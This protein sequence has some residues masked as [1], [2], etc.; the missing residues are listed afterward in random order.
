M[1]TVCSP[2]VATPPPPGPTAIVT[3]PPVAG[4]VEPTP[5]ADAAAPLFAPTPTGDD[6]L[7]DAPPTEPPTEVAPSAPA[8]PVLTVYVDQS[9]PGVA[10]LQTIAQEWGAANGCVVTILPKSADDLRLDFVMAALAGDA[11][12]LVVASDTA[13]APFVA[14]DLLLPAGDWVNAADFA[15]PVVAAAAI[16]GTQWGIPLSVE[17][18][19]MLLYNKKLIAVPPATTNDL[20]RTPKPEAAEAIFIT[21]QNDPRWLLPW[22]NGWGG[23]V[24]GDDGRPT[25]NAPPMVSTF[26]FL[27][28]LRA[29]DVSPGMDFAAGSDLFKQ[30]RAA[31][32]VDG[33]WSVPW[34]MDAAMAAPDLLDLGVARLPVVAGTNGAAASY[35]GGRYV[36]VPRGTADARRELARA[37]VATLT[38]APTQARWASETRRLPAR[39]ETLGGETVQNDPLLKP[40]ADALAEAL[41]FPTQPAFAVLWDTLGSRTGAVMAGDVSPE[42]AAQDLQTAAE[43]ILGP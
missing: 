32:I 37:F 43:A 20:L 9:D 27:H 18:Q 36:L 23:G 13:I 25:L 17:G 42:T 40:Q 19:M 4:T 8:V 28:R 31:M 35:V 29:D 39:L 33:D 14:D 7:S 41:P 22:L 1:L 5:Q 12:D 38:S 30:G 24:L 34:Y 3:V 26:E 21:N 2:P 15:S 6:A 11:P 16:D 10:F